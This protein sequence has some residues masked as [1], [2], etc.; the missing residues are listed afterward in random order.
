MK[1]IAIGGS[2]KKM[3]VD[4]S[5]FEMMSKVVWKVD[6]V[7]YCAGSVGLTLASQ[8]GVPSGR[9]YAHRLIMRPEGKLTVDHINL[10]KL[11][12]QRE[13]LRICTHRENTFN[14]PKR[15]DSISSKYIGVHWCNTHKAWIASISINRK[16]KR[17]RCGSE[18]EAALLYNELAL[19]HRGPYARLNQIN[20]GSP[21]VQTK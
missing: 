12:N 9:W 16:Q 10:N 8:I 17:K 20:H 2:N 13:N 1:E 6:R 19:K 4:D 7:G 18:V 14:R 21:T 15:K 3:L 11:D 5:D